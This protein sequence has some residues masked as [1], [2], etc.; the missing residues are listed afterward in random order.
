MTDQ[1]KDQAKAKNEKV[2]EVKSDPKPIIDNPPPK[3]ENQRL[4]EVKKDIKPF[5]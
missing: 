4:S 3:A 1:S 2:G 5:R